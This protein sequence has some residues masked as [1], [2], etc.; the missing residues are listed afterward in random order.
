[1]TDVESD[2]CRKVSAR[3]IA[4]N[5]ETGTR[6]KAGVVLLAS[7]LFLGMS[8]VALPGEL[9]GR[10]SIIDGDTLEIHGS[11]IRLWGIDAPEGP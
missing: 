6:A 3:G 5:S 10:A 7:L 11:R 4:M 2:L 8:G 1:M 9:A